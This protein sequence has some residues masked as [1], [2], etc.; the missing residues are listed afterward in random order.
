MASVGVLLVNSN[1]LPHIAVAQY[2]FKSFRLLLY[3]FCTTWQHFYK[4]CMYHPQLC[5]AGR[6]TTIWDNNSQRDLHAHHWKLLHTAQFLV[7]TSQIFNPGIFF[8]SFKLL[9]YIIK[10]SK[11]ITRFHPDLMAFAKENTTLI[12]RNKT[13]WAWIEDT[14]IIIWNIYKIIPEDSFFY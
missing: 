5:S 10:S 8:S 11:P 14:V 1:E 12:K 13:V 2:M 7:T 6:P 9:C 4:C 3:I